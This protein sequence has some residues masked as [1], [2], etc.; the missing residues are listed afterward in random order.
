MQLFGLEK[1]AFW[2]IFPLEKCAEM[3]KI[4]LE[5]WKKNLDFSCKMLYYTILC[6]PSPVSI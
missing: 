6:L 3:P 5:K 2:A 1:C 4:P